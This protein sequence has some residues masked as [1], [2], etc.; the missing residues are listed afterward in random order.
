MKLTFLGTGAADWNIA[1]YDSMPF[2]RRNSSALI[3]GTLL[4]DPGPHVFHFAEKNGTPDLLDGVKNIIVTHSHG[5]HF[6]PET[7][8]RLCR[9]RDCTLWCSPECMKVLGEKLGND[10]V[11]G[12]NFRSTEI[13][14]TYDI[15]GYTVT[16]L[17]ANHFATPGEIAR[18]YLVER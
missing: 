3:D 17:R 11:F 15:D 5:D 1:A 16:P 6:C 2:F 4:I 13:G 8:V 12:I 9:D 18:T 10:G 14:K 7:V